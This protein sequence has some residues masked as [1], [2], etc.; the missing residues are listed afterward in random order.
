MHRLLL[1]EFTCGMPEE[2]RHEWLAFVM[3]W[4]QF[5]GPIMAKGFE[6]AALYL[7]NRLLS[8]N[9]VGSDP[10]AG[11]ITVAEFH[12]RMLARQ[13]DFPHTMNATSTHDTKRS[14]DVRARLN[15]L[16]EMP[17]VWTERVCQWQE[18]NAPKK[19]LP[20][21]KPVPLSNEELFLYQTLIGAW[22]LDKAEGVGF[23]DRLTEYIVKASR[24]AK[25]YTSWLDPSE[26]YEDA[27]CAFARL[28]LED[29]GDNR[30]R[31]DLLRLL[32]PLA[33]YGAFNSLAQLV[34]KTVCPGVPDYYMGSELWHYSLVDPDNRRPVD[35]TRRMELPAEL[36]QRETDEAL[37]REL[38][39]SW[40]DG[41]I[42][43]YVTWKALNLRRNKARFFSHGKYLPLDATGTAQEHV[44][45]LARHN[46]GD[47]VVAAMPH[48]PL[49]L[50][51]EVSAAALTAALAE[52]K[53]PT[54]REYWTDTALHLPRAAP[55]RWQNIFSA[56]ILSA[57]RQILPLESVFSIFPV[58]LLTP[59]Y[60]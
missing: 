1:L 25:A 39:Q 10:A 54:G 24:E 28:I 22:P 23:M 45:A 37:P 42:K 43:L 9:E 55:Y 27:F 2:T 11:S 7:D 35:F 41:R 48:L 36:Q 34:L 38:L 20:A 49:R 33:Y 21:G 12:R 52:V 50:L 29:S 15:L 59:V 26:A 56:E 30:F 47:W 53:A 8:I 16:S 13:T 46:E 44:C 5:S 51:S 58:A 31:E 32:K 57:D 6:D 18:W 60:G 17:Q 19:P 4:Q 3:C 40:D 14:E